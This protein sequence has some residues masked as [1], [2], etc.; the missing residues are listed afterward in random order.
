M[1][2][3]SVFSKHAREVSF[4]IGQMDLNPCPLLFLINLLNIMNVIYK[5]PG[6]GLFN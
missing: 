6:V 3:L 2:I 5:S 4:I 1:L